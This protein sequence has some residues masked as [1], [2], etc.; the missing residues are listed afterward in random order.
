[1]RLTSETEEERTA[2]M[3]QLHSN[4]HKRLH[5]ESAEERENRLQQD[6][7][8]HVKHPRNSQIPLLDQTDVK[9]KMSK[10]HSD[11]LSLQVAQCDTCSETSPGLDINPVSSNTSHTECKCCNQ[12]KHIPKLYSAANNM[13][14]GLVPPELQVC[15]TYCIYCICSTVVVCIRVHVYLGNHSYMYVVV[16]TLLVAEV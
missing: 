6:R 15:T 4:R 2:R 7:A 10:F 9:R 12:D 5:S 16:H 11:L 3:Q 8:R 1:M 14:P 13:D